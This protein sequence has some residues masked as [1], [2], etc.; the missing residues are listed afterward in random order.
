MKIYLIR[1]G[2]TTGDLEDRYGGDYDDHLTEEGK[3]QAE[4]L[5]V[6]L[7]LRGIEI[8]FCSSLVRA[9]ET[10]QIV[11]NKLSVTVETI[12]ELKERNQ[13][14]ILTGMIKAEAKEK[15]PEVAQ[16]VKD[17]KNTIEGAENYED[18]KGRVKGAFERVKGSGKEVVAVIT[19]G[20]QIR[21]IFREILNFGEIDVT[22]CAFAVLEGTG[23]S[24]EVRELKGI[25]S[26]TD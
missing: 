14:G 24:F 26:R 19:H 3:K 9:Q 21:T 13:Y 6:E 5:A 17:Y 10:A 11:N 1:H 2:Q 4:E 22:D 7:A 23:K 18:F 8:I 15:H 25:T 20:G 12:P 16:E